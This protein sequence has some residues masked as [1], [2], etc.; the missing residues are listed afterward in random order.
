MLKSLLAVSIF[1]FSVTAKAESI[2][3]KKDSSIVFCLKD[4]IPEAIISGGIYAAILNPISIALSV[5]Y[6][7][8]SI[9]KCYEESESNKKAAEELEL[10][11]KLVE[12]QVKLFESKINRFESD[13]SI[14][15]EKVSKS[16]ESMKKEVQDSIMKVKEDYVNLNKSLAEYSTLI[17]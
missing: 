11:N 14:M 1:I 5:G 10:K 17:G 8:N 3:S 2:E 4:N 15:A 6:Y 7:G 12:E 9:Y 13:Y 16:E